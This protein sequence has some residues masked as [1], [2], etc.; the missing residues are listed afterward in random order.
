MATFLIITIEH[1]ERIEDDTH[2]QWIREMIDVSTAE[3]FI[4]RR[5]CEQGGSYNSWSL[6][7][8][9]QY[10]NH[11]ALNPESRTN[12]LVYRDAVVSK[13][14]KLVGKTKQDEWKAVANT[15]KA[16]ERVTGKFL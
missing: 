3:D 14:W 2:K 7:T 5:L 1:L 13:V 15:V 11:K 6:F 12:Q 16:M 10:L 9:V 4:Q 8:M